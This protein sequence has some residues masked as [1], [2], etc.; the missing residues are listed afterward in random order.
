MFGANRNKVQVQLYKGIDDLWI[1]AVDSQPPGE[2]FHSHEEQNTEQD[3]IVQHSWLGRESVHSHEN[4]SGRI[5]NVKFKSAK[6]EE[7]TV[8]P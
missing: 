1:L 2:Y 5:L 3:K 8:W 7:F 6:C 4:V